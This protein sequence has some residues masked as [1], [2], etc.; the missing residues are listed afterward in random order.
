VTTS[1][2]AVL[3][4]GEAGSRL[5]ADL[6]AAGVEVHG[7]DPATSSTPDRV[8][9]APDPVS[10]AAAGTVVLCAVTAAAA[11][12]AATS[13]L[14]GLRRGTVYADLNTAAPALKRELAKLVVGAGARFAD[15]A[16]LGSVPALGLRT[17]ML[18]S[19]DGAGAFAEAVAPLGMSVQVLS[20]EPG[21]AAER[22]LIRSV[23]MKGLAAAA[24]ESL[25]AGEAAGHATWLQNQLGEMIGPDLLRR[26]VEGSR[27]HA[28]RRVDEMDAACEL[29]ASLGIE[30]RIAAASRA[31]LADLARAPAGGVGEP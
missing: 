11:L 7:Y 4:L 9:R 8:I 12:A 29:L 6:A 31:L 3:G 27:R 26:F 16:M 20:S 10:A 5:A 13:A 21:D 30:P 19:G 22:K 1:V 23:F 24:L 2:V 17:P 28:A 15:V 14:P 25:A 18:V